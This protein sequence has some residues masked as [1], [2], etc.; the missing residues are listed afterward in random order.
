MA[1]ER[2]PKSGKPKKLKFKQPKLV[3]FD[4]YAQLAPPE[5]GHYELHN[6]RIIPIPKSTEAHQ[7]VALKLALQ[8]GNYIVKNKLGKLLSPPIDVIFS[9]NDALKP[10]ILFVSNERL[11]IID[12]QVKG[13]PDFIVEIGN[14]E[15]GMSYRKYLF[16]LHGVDE[17]WLINLVKQTITQ[18]ENIEDELIIR[19]KIN[20][21]GSLSSVI[22]DGF[23]LK[24]SDIFE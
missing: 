4:D 17:Y 3:T 7:T 9:P 21:D 23:S 12:N 6:G 2:A 16:G 11:S 15:K 24:A 20:R 8:L 14:T 1:A 18:Y 5:S 19:T 10:D 22:I 13:A